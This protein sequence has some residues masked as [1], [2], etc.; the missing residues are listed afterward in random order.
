MHNPY[1]SIISAQRNSAQRALS[2]GLASCPESAA[3]HYA[4]GR[5]LS[6]IGG[7]DAA[8]IAEFKTAKALRPNELAH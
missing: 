5:Q 8:A 4:Y 6:R 2:A 7:N 1:L 3:L